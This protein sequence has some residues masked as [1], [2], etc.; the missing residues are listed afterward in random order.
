MVIIPLG[1]ELGALDANLEPSYLISLNLHFIVC[2]MK[3]RQLT[4]KTYL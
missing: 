3:R 2:K 4:Y 1:L